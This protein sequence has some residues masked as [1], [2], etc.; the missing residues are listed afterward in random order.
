MYF[1]IRSSLEPFSILTAEE[2]TVDCHGA[3]ASCQISAV[4]HYLKI[5]RSMGVGPCEWS[6]V[7]TF[8]RIPRQMVKGLAGLAVLVASAVPLVALAGS[9]SAAT[10]PTLTCSVASNTTIVPCT[11][12]YA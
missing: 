9:A 12:G 7:N 3:P 6:E 5:I 4:P 8:R 1:S 11:N 10:A 2:A